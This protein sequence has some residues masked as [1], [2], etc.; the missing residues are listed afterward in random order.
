MKSLLAGIAMAAV[1]LTATV[2]V[3]AVSAPANAR[4]VVRVGVPV[5]APGIYVY[6]G[7]HYRYRNGGRYY[8]SRYWCTRRHRR[9][10]YR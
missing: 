3:D 1:A 8:N 5:V 10:C 6:Q 4:V 9:W 7:R 2:A